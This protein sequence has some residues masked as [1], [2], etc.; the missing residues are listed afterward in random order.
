[1][2]MM[3]AQSPMKEFL[4]NTLVGQAF[5]HLVQLWRENKIYSLEVSLVKD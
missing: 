2:K 3:S 5:N 1:M 4:E